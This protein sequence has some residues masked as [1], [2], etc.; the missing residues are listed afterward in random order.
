MRQFIITVIVTV[1]LGGASVSHAGPWVKQP[2]EAYVK[3]GATW[4]EAEDGFNQGVSTGLAYTGVTYNLY[5]EVGLPGDLQLVADIPLVLATNQSVAGVN[6]NNRTLGDARLEVDYALLPE[7]PL[8]LGLE[9][10]I[11]LY[12]TLAN[13]GSN[14]EDYPQS[15]EKFPDAGDGNFDLTP[16]LLFGYSF[17]PVPAWAT[18]ELW[19]RARLG[20]FADGLH[21]A[22]G[23]GIFAV[24]DVLAFGVY[25]SGVLNL[26][27]DEEGSSVQTKEYGYGQVYVLFKGLPVDPDLGLTV[28]IGRIA[29]ARHASVGTDVS[30]GVS[31]GF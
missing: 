5:G 9:A 6:Y 13:G 25:A 7:L 24:P 1:G 28:S 2:G 11:P 21:W 12:T 4:F 27:D 20:G 29:Y 15:A 8:T 31:H 14:I 19:Y 16:K 3:A 23:G 18:A 22:V 17:H 10:K 26:Q 30:A